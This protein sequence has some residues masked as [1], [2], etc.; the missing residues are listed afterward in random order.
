MNRAAK[1][2]HCALHWWRPGSRVSWICQFFSAALGSPKD[3]GVTE[4]RLVAHRDQSRRCNSL[5]ATEGWS[6]EAPL[7]MTPTGRFPCG[8]SVC[9]LRWRLGSA[10]VMRTPD[11]AI[12]Q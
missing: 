1:R 8:S 2:E 3:K 7:R 4:C 6:R 12:A 11:F 9:R 10:K 5:V